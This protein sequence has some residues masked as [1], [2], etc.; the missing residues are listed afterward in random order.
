VVRKWYDIVVRYL[1]LVYVILFLAKLTEIL[2]KLFL[3]AAQEKTDDVLNDEVKTNWNFYSPKHLCVFKPV[4]FI[5]L[6]LLVITTYVMQN[7]CS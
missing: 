5:L 6:E 4:S 7:A 2:Q 3:S 1:N